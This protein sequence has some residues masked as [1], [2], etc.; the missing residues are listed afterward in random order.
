MSFE[1]NEDNL[2]EQ[3]TVD[4]LASIGWEIETAWHNETFG[5]D[6]LLGRVNKDEVILKRYLLAALEKL[7]PG[8]PSSAYKDAYLTIAQKESGKTIA[9]INKEKYQLLKD[10]VK[11]SFINNKG[12][13]E[14]K[15]LRVFD[16]NDP[17][18]NH[19]L[20]SLVL[21]SIFSVP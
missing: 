15:T 4:I 1:Y 8:H 14:K 7:N 12:Q 16:F 18:N 17:S 5:V 20:A 6:S 13:L 2:V 21:L 10:G 3:A 19:F 11:V 9:R